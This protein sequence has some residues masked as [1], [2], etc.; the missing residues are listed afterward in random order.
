[1]T[2]RI[3]GHRS[4]PG[5][6]QLAQHLPGARSGHEDPRRHLIEAKILQARLGQEAGGRRL[7][8]DPQQRGH[9]PHSHRAVVAGRVLDEHAQRVR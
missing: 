7:V 4:Q 9:R 3:L 1:M 2:A 8:A 5:G 6:A